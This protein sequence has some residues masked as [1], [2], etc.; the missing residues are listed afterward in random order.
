MKEE[1]VV[2]FKADTSDLDK[3]ESKIKDIASGSSATSKSTAATSANMGEVVGSLE[4][5]KR[6]DAFSLL[7]Q[8]LEKV[9]DKIKDVK[10]QFKNFK[11]E[12][13]LAY[14]LPKYFFKGGFKDPVFEEVLAESNMSKTVFAWK[15]GITLIKRQ[16]QSLG[17][18]VKSVGATIKAVLTSI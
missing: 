6:L 13:E 9:A 12:R 7:S 10:E 18:V 14:K 2:E 4:A 16:F 5:I 1:F 15:M 17:A 3:A 8:S 11:V